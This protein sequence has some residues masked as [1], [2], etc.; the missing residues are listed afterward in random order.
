MWKKRDRN[1]T[2]EQLVYERKLKE[3]FEKNRKIAREQIFPVVLKFATNAKH[4]ENTL[5]IF[6]NVITQLMQ[7]PYKTM[8]L[9][10]LNMGEELTQDDKAPDREFHMALIESLKDIEIVDV[11]K[12]LDG[13]AGALNGY[14]MAE[15]GK[16]P[17]SEISIDD[18]V[19]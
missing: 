3:V 18:I 16:K 4:A 6:K 9:E 12:L 15:A 19:K 8:K 7:K 13:M 5:N 10:G 17:M 11:M 2:K 14:T 1:K